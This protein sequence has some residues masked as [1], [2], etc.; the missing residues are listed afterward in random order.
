MVVWWFNFFPRSLCISH[1]S[2]NEFISF[3]NK[4]IYWVI[5]K[6]F[7]VKIN[8]FSSSFDGNLVMYLVH[9]IVERFAS[10]W[11]PRKQAENRRKIEFEVFCF[12]VLLA[13]FCD[14]INSFNFWEKM[15]STERSEENKLEVFSFLMK[16]I[17]NLT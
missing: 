12:L 16:E 3:P 13:V 2:P 8:A 9:S 14:V 10:V 17:E 4:S 15:A 6:I 5:Q 7:Q 11:L 1:Q